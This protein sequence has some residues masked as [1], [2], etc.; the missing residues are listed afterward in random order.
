MMVRDEIYDDIAIEKLLD[1]PEWLDG[2]I[3]NAEVFRGFIC[4]SPLFG[5]NDADT[6]MIAAD[7]RTSHHQ[8]IATG[9]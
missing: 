6:I 7:K 5:I 3:S 8:R 4:G 9:T 2:A 1:Q